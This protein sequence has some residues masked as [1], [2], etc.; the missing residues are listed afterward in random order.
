MKKT[1]RLELY[2]YGG[3]YIDKELIYEGADKKEIAKMIDR[4]QNDLLQYMQTGD[5]NNQKA[6]CFCG[7]MFRKKG[8]AAA[9]ISEPEY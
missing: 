2:F 7:Y 5:E 6:F 9:Q 4:D 3:G 8:I 1:M